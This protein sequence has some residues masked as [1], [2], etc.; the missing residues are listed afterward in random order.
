VFSKIIFVLKNQFF[1]PLVNVIFPPICYICEYYLPADRKIICQ[2]CWDK[3]PAFDGQLDTALSKRSFDQI[4]ILFEFQD[5]IRLL[6]HLL[7][8]KRH[9]TLASYFALQA[10]SR[11]NLSEINYY[12]EIVP[13]PLYKTRERERGYNQSEVIANA[14]SKII[15]V[16]VETEHL[17]RIRP[18]S[19]Q[20]RMSREERE[21]NVSMAFSCPRKLKNRNILLIDDVITTGSTTEACMQVLKNAGAKKVG[22]LVIAHPLEND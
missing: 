17:L 20:T 16:P 2:T 9:L 22:V 5:T 10:N 4:F 15:K 14:L 7:K 8:Y 13:V 6:I 21:F 3:I 19:T 11:F 12:D 1:D 18:T